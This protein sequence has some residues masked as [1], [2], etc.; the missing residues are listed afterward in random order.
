M[1]NESIWGIDNGSD[2]VVGALRLSYVFAVVANALN[3]FRQHSDK[4]KLEGIQQTFDSFEVSKIWWKA[5]IRIIFY[6]LIDQSHSLRWL[7]DNVSHLFMLVAHTANEYLI[8][9]Q[10][11]LFSPSRFCVFQFG[12]EKDR[13]RNENVRMDVCDVHRNEME[14]TNCVTATTLSN[15]HKVRCVWLWFVFNIQSAIDQNPVFIW[16]R[17]QSDR[18]FIAC[19]LGC[20]VRYHFGRCIRTSYRTHNWGRKFVIPF[21]VKCPW[22]RYGFLC[23]IFI[24]VV[25]GWIHLEIIYYALSKCYGLRYS[26]V[27]FARSVQINRLIALRYRTAVS[28]CPGCLHSGLQW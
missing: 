2:Q 7:F 26:F 5:N 24:S 27:R 15:T 18:L 8:Q 9:L 22:N 23:S 4:A 16:M 20:E 1:G 17:S 6:S 19:V 3:C 12:G 10:I 13:A 21:D 25:I 14:A 11:T 28:C